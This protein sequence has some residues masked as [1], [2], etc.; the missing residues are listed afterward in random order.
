M[1]KQLDMSF[2][3]MS[4][5]DNSLA[6]PIGRR[7]SQYGSQRNSVRGDGKDIRRQSSRLSVANIV[8]IRII[9]DDNDKDERERA[10]ERGGD[11]EGLISFLPLC[12]QM[13][14]Q[15]LIIF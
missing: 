8:R 2:D 4:L 15:W 12:P 14:D 1:T 6:S 7:Y 13:D 11:G 10:C 5:R 9:R 3:A